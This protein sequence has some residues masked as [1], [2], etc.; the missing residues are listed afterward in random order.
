[1][2]MFLDPRLTTIY[3]LPVAPIVSII[4]DPTTVGATQAAPLGAEEVG[5]NFNIKTRKAS[6]SR[7]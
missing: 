1:M 6:Q 7:Q 4:S 2:G 5:V 3:S